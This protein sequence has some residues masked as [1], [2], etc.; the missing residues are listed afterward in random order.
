MET[1]IDER[2]R[3]FV[4]F[5]KGKVA[6]N[7]QNK[8]APPQ[9]DN[10][11]AKF[12]LTDK[13]QN[14]SSLVSFAM[15]SKTCGFAT[16]LN[17]ECERECKEDEKHEFSVE[18]QK[19]KADIFAGKARCDAHALY[20]VNYLIVMMFHR[21]GGGMMHAQLF[22][23]FLGLP[24]FF[25]IP[26]MFRAVENKLGPVLESVSVNSMQKGLA[27]EREATKRNAAKNGNDIT[28][29]DGK[30]GISVASDTHWPRR[31]GGGK[32]Y[33]SPSGLTYM[34]GCLSG[35]IVACHICS[36]DC[37]V[38]SYFERKK[39]ESNLESDATV[40]PHR[41]P[42]NFPKSKS[43]K[44]METYSTVLM[45]KGIFESIS[46]VFV[47]YI[48]IDD[49]TC[50]MAHLRRKCD[51]GN[52]PDFM[53]FSYPIR[54]SDLNHRI[55]SIGH[56]IFDLARAK[57][58]KSRLTMEVAY[59]Y[60]KAV[61]YFI[62]GMIS[63]K[64]T[65]KEFMANK[66]API[67]HLFGN[68][69]YCTEHCPGKRALQKNE[70]YT[71]KIPPLDKEWHRDI[72]LDIHECTAGYFEEERVNQ[73]IREN[74]PTEIVMKGTQPC[75]AVNNADIT[76]APKNRHY[77]STCS[78]ADRSSTMIGTH[79]LGETVFYSL[80]A[81]DIIDVPLNTNILAYLEYKWE[82]K[83]YRRNYE[84]TCGVKRKRTEKS[85]ASLKSTKKEKLVE[86]ALREKFGEGDMDAHKSTMALMSNDEVDA[87]KKEKARLLKL[88]TTPCRSC[89]VMGHYNKT[90]WR[91]EMNEFNIKNIGIV[92]G[93]IKDDRESKKA[94]VLDKD[95]PAS[96][97]NAQLR[98]RL[99][100]LGLKVGGNKPE[101]LLRL[102][103]ATSPASGDASAGSST[104]D[105]AS[106][107]ITSKAPSKSSTSGEAIIPTSTVTPG[108]SL[109]VVDKAPSCSSPVNKTTR[110]AAPTAA[111]T[112][113]AMHAEIAEMM[114]FQEM[115]SGGL[116][117][118]P[119]PV[120]T[121]VEM[122]VE[123]T[124]QS[125]RAG[126]FDDLDDTTG[127]LAGVSGTDDLDDL[128]AFFGDL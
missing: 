19:V 3:S 15:T 89:G 30:V 125:S 94:I 106:T 81:R 29:I 61:S 44:T 5:H 90:D 95:D 74:M 43:P 123:D 65:A 63:L 9:V 16:T 56:H 55:R 13:K 8:K 32:K 66:L 49:D 103:A 80:V 92:N 84:S 75:E 37:R 77:S 54:I 52:L 97:T 112:P 51:G 100:A 98:E 4:E 115:L 38:C 21:M 6:Q 110:I 102:S 18:P 39:K 59:R 101:L 58:D 40:R 23:G 36:Q 46:N 11:Y 117:H 70:E 71:P 2:M 116:V 78:L 34:I 88:A 119:I 20:W 79:N 50:M 86:E 113:A 7:K 28:T 127:G 120:E 57:I 124:V 60:K 72:Y 111:T 42:R 26:Y 87:F 85:K 96:L 114:D 48:C 105:D 108:S 91:C 68:H 12:K 53:P 31:G 67:E 109:P 1:I 104:S 33:V 76:M 24:S 128:C 118:N 69:E 10:S 93:K 122:H 62:Y 27:V 121:P 83:V 99:K 35:M 45:V 17:F 107:S 41:C 14:S 82:K 64:C 25:R 47:E 73:I 126:I 22:A